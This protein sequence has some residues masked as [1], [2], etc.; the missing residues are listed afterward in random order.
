MSNTEK[1]MVVGLG[2]IGNPLLEVISRRH[3]T[4]GVDIAPPAEPPG[5]I[6]VMH[7]CYPY[8]IKD[9][10]GETARYI[11]RYNPSLTVIHSTVAV[12][13][14]RAVAERTGATVVE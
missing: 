7:V 3:K 12:G 4:I 5:D 8:K 10:I 11:K 1:I 13:T 14:T 9:F 6:D 2:E